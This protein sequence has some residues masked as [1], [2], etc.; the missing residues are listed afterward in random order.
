MS[1][2][3]L[4]SIMALVRGYGIAML[5]RDTREANADRLKAIE[6]AIR[7]AIAA[8]GV[9]QGWKPITTA[10][11][12]GEPVLLWWRFAGAMRG[13]FVNDQSGDGWMC[14]GDQILP[15]NQADCTHWM[16]LPAAPSPTAEQPVTIEPTEVKP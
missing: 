1:N 11:M 9:A 15:I 14:D 3:Q 6:V 2:D 12:F 8:P 16:P 7:E 13:R 4:Q 10:P 5:S